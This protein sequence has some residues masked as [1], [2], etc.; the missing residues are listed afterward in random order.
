VW[1]YNVDVAVAAARAGFDE[2]MFDYVRF[3]S[4][5]DISTLKF[6]QDYTEEVRVATINAFLEE[7]HRRINPLGCAVAADIFAITLESSNDEGIGQVPNDL[8]QK[9]DVLSPMI[10]TY[11]YGK[12]WKGY[13]DPNDHALALVTDALDSGR[14]RLEGFAIYRPWIQTW[15]LE[16]AEMRQV[17]EAVAERG[18]GWMLWSATTY[19]Q[20]EMLPPE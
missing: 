3:P 13:E 11:T 17:Q 8:S 16:P 4:D 5:G 19:F 20:P 2:I 12:G 14:D 10:Y 15:L 1:D 9:I 18:W 7:A 6:D